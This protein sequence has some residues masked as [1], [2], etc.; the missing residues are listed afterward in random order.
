GAK[1]PGYWSPFVEK[2][3]KTD[4][5]LRLAE[6]DG[7]IHTAGSEVIL[8]LY[9]TT[10]KLAQQ[11]GVYD[12]INS[13]WEEVR[14]L[15]SSAAVKLT[16]GEGAVSVTPA[17]SGSYTIR[18]TARDEQDRTAVTELSFYAT[19]ADWIR[20]GA[21]D[22]T[23]IGLEPDKP[24]YKPGD[25]AKLLLKTSLPEGYYL[26][27]VEREGIYSE[28][29]MHIK[30]SANLIDIPVEEAYLP[31][32]Y[33]SVASYS[34][35]TREPDHTYFEPDLDKPKGYFGMATLLVD[36][37]S[38]MIDIKVDSAEP[39]YLPGGEAQVTL[40]ATSGGKP[41]EGADLTFLA[42]DRGVLDLIDY[43]VPDPLKFF[44]STYRFPLG[45]LGADSRSLLID[46]VTYQVKNLH[47]GDNGG[48][49]GE[50][51]AGE[52]GKSLAERKDFNPT[53]VFLPSLKTDKNGKAV[54][55]FKLPDTLTTYRL[56]AL[57]AKG[58]RFGTAEEEIKVQNPI[59]VKTAFPRKLR[60]RDTAIGSILLTNLQNRP[61]KVT[62]TVSFD[63]LEIDGENSY[64][65]TIP[66]ARTL[67]VPFMFLAVKPGTATVTVTTESGVLN[68]KLTETLVVEKPYVFESFT[69]IGRT[70]EKGTSGQG[71][72]E[73]GF[74]IPSYIEDEQGSLSITAAG[75]RLA[76]LKDAVN[77]VFTYPY[78]C[79]E[80]RS[81]RMLPLVLF[82]DY[83][84]DFGLAA[85]VKDPKK[86]VEEELA[87]WAKFQKEDGGFPFWLEDTYSGSSYYVSLRVAHI[88]YHAKRKGYAVP[89]SLNTAGLLRY[90]QNPGSSVSNSD[91]LMIYKIYVLSLHGVDAVREANR[92]FAKGDGIGLSG[93]G[94]L[95]LA[96]LNTGNR[97]R[98][99]ECLAAVKRF[100]RPGTQ[101]IDLTDTYET[102]YF[103]NS[104]VEQLSLLLM[105]HAQLEDTTDMTTRI[106]TTLM[107]RQKNG[108]WYNTADTSWALQAFASLMEQGADGMPDFK[109]AVTLE[110]TELMTASF[111][112]PADPP[113]GRIFAL[114][115]PPLASFKK[116]TMYPLRFALTG[117]GTL[118]YTATL[119][120][121]V[122]AEITDARDEGLG[123]LTEITDLEGRIVAGNSLEA[124]KTYRMRAVISSP[125][126]RAYLA[127]RLPVPSGADI[128][129]TSFVTTAR[130]KEL[131]KPATDENGYDEYGY[132][133]DYY[134]YASRPRE[135]ILDNEVQYF[136]DDFPQG[137]QEVSLLF[138]TLNRGVYPTPPAAAECMYEPEI[139]GRTE[140]RIYFIDTGK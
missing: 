59:N 5:T 115:A 111:S 132:D 112:S 133:D 52:D 92:Y 85:E 136:W 101:T 107:Q 8:E 140:G 41:V 93:Y 11:Q 125:K 19:G 31:I 130:Y 81:S 54:V 51:E 63:I 49:D 32:V 65:L 3:K 24:L 98:A 33:V 87:F 29:V 88:L 89:P 64:T 128:L 2:G 50:E 40:T 124:G 13:R 80:Q 53:A 16:G 71:A 82:G 104:Q 45:V 37:G 86:T 25:T 102:G 120:Y 105:L 46:P 123:V 137:K 108:Y 119:K 84:D 10:W 95:G 77:Y 9:H 48:K 114:N 122:P 17:E 134:Y 35:R 56:T 12:Y 39:V 69:T 30:G 83:I 1:A 60:Y 57:A 27:T 121:A 14:D 103:Y 76:S 28:K 110:N 38:R 22:M 129:D 23:E 74:I 138:R 109:A 68:E 43:H 116:D 62:V 91:Y 94:L 131:D 66:A 79:M 127:L 90:L 6:P 139:F 126:R 15:E 47:G 42:V 118:F 97:D 100:I 106:V 26:V 73:E 7:K 4:L 36:T 58:N 18:L 34:R 113:Q 20:W 96:Y 67:E 72:S 99:L 78:G 55:T 21:D 44:Y 135:K 70:S 117:K 61:N 75:S